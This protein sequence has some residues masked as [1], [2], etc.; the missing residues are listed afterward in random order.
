MRE[1][2]DRFRPVI[3]T[4]Q[5][6]IRNAF[7][8]RDNIN[9]L[10]TEENFTGDIDLLSI[11]IDGNDYYVWQAV[12]A[13][14]PRVVVIEYNAKFPPDMEWKQAYNPGHVWDGSDW[15]G[16]SLKAYELL[17][18]E[19][20]YQLVGTNFNGVNAFFVRQDLAWDMFITPATAENL[21]TPLRLGAIRFVAGGHKAHYCLVGQQEGLGIRNY[22]EDGKIPQENRIK[23]FI[24]QAIHW[25][26]YTWRNG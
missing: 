19:L 1:I 26:G 12:K 17:G 20:G 25:A 15:Q 11:D 16:A 4:G 5:L 7:I 9:E 2:Q 24:R 21:Y 3:K 10:F 14:R 23:R 6:K 18:R 8:T 13:V 22:Y